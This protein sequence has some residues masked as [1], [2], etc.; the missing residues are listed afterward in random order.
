MK[1]NIISGGKLKVKTGFGTH[2]Y[3]RSAVLSYAFS[4][5][6]ANTTSGNLQPELFFRF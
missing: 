1:E 2:G 3:D 5:E 6:S 4:N